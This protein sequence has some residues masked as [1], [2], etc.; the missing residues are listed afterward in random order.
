[1]TLS[2]AATRTRRLI[3]VKRLVHVKADRSSQQRSG[4]D[5]SRAADRPGYRDQTSTISST[6]TP[7]ASADSTTDW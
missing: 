1:M 7:A 2:A 3:V 4:R 6:L 5:D